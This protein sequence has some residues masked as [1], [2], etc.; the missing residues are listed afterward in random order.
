LKVQKTPDAADEREALKAMASTLLDPTAQ[1]ADVGVREPHKPKPLLEDVLA[2]IPEAVVIVEGDRVLYTNPAFTRV[3]GFT[4]DEIDEGKLEELIVPGTRRRECTQVRK[5]V[6]RDGFAELETVRLNKNGGMVDVALNAAPLIVNGEKTGYVLCYRD[7]GERKRNEA[8]LQHDSLH[9]ALTGLPNR[10]LFIDRLSLAFSRRA[11]RTGQSCGVLFLDLDRFKE[12]NDSL[13]HA[14]GDEVLAGVAERLRSALRPQDTAARLGGDEFA[15]LVENIVSIADIEIVAN[16]ILRAMERTFD[17]NN[18]SIHVGASIGVAVAAPEHAA[19]E[20]LVR[21]ADFAMYRAKQEGGGRIEIFDKKLKVHVATRQERERELRHVLDARQFEVWYQPIMRLQNGKLEGFE[22]QLRWRKEDDSVHSMSSLL[23]VAEETGLSISLGRET[24]EIACKQLRRWSEHL[25]KTGVTLAIGVTE[26]QFFH[27][28]FVAQV[29]RSL[30]ASGA[31]PARLLVE[32]PE[33]TLSENPEVAGELIHRL[34]G[35]NVR[36][37]IANFG[38]G[39]APLNLLVRLPIDVLKLD[40]TLIAAALS[41]GRQVAALESLIQ[42]GRSLGV[43]V[44]A[45]GI[46]TEEQKN[47]L[48]H[49]GCELG[50]GP[51]LWPPLDSERAQRLAGEGNEINSPKD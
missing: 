42:L 34:V 36:V 21:D 43:Q 25:P 51:M 32:V 12:I 17:I 29:K 31:D 11:R 8:K 45:E 47:A 37:A 14:V 2:C 5:T 6:D 15:I 27:A 13:G 20:M 41:T 16:R 35:T 28:D 40:R 33:T 1:S 19:P 9:D 49:M 24:M 39:L 46:E 44:I 50:Q 22:S 18:R 3:F 48:C 38:S 7:I 10:A 23:P 30:A 26:R 4:A